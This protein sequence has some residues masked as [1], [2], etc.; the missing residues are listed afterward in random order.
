MPR[1][2]R[3]RAPAFAGA[4]RAFAT[5]QSGL[6]QVASTARVTSPPT[7]SERRGPAP[8]P[9]HLCPSTNRSKGSHAIRR[10]PAASWATS[11]WAQR[12]LGAR[13]LPPTTRAQ[14]AVPLL[15]LEG[16]GEVDVQRARH[17]GSGAFPLDAADLAPEPGDAPVVSVGCRWAAEA[18][19][20]PSSHPGRRTG[21]NV[22]SHATVDAPSRLTQ[23]LRGSQEPF[24]SGANVDWSSRL[25]STGPTT[26]Q[27]GLSLWAAIRRWT[28]RERAL[29][30]PVDATTLRLGLSPR[31]PTWTWRHPE[32][33]RRAPT[34]HV[35]P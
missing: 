1:Q 26:L 11:G 30:A 18:V 17:T 32:Q 24:G 31:T 7:H 25:A 28:R 15:F 4:A 21:G 16:L 12:L 19:S 8:L 23:V 27:L 35:K 33:A 10:D 13:R 2:T 34:F 29:G 6:D 14:P 22:G 20:R 9:G 5:G 3:V